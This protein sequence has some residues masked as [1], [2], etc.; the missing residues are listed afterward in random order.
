M[1]VACYL[2]YKSSII[3]VNRLK[4]ALLFINKGY[5]L[6]WGIITSVGLVKD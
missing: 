6:K 5:L 4:C 3:Y 2:E 1:L